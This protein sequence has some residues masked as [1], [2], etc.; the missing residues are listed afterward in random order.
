MIDGMEILNTVTEAPS[1]STVL[2][3]LSLLI[4]G[5]FILLACICAYGICMFIKDLY[6]FELMDVA[7]ILLLILLMAI[8]GFAAY[9]VID[10]GI[11]T[12]DRRETVVYATI[13]DS[14]PWS[15]VNDRYELIGQDGKI[16]RLRLRE[17]D[18]D[19]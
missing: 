13:D 11:T 19:D 15:A 9:A 5:L 14:V 8:S 7:Q 2:F 12:K 4:G 16:Y 17:G 10:D 6:P 1:G 3:I 18:G